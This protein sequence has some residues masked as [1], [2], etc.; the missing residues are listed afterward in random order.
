MSKIINATFHE[1]QCGTLYTKKAYQYDRGVVLRIS[2]IALPEQYEVHFSDR[3]DGG[4]STSLKVSGSDV[5]I[6]NAYFRT[7]EYVYVWIF[8]TDGKYSGSSEYH[9]V[10][11]VTPRPINIP[12]DASTD[13]VAYLGDDEEEH[14]LIFDRK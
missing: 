8:I 9:A 13:V 2:G 14:T 6:P 5:Q 1:G 3:E 7:G 11:P 4:I 12:I 10:I